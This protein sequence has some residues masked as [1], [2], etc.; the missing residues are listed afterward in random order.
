[1]TTKLSTSKKKQPSSSEGP[2]LK[3]LETENK[4][5]SIELKEKTEK[6]LR[7][8]A[9]LSNAQKRLEK[10]KQYHEELLRK[11]Y[12]EVLLDFYDVL[13][14]AYV[15]GDPKPGLKLLM[16]NLEKFFDSEHVKPIVCVGQCFDP[17]YHH[18]ITT[19]ENENSQDNCIIEEVK[20]GYLCDEKVLRPSQVIV[21]KKKTREDQR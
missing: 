16:A 7:A 19:V 2:L 6:Y 12:L 4:R 11:K 9:E 10:E 5:L 3:T 14:K 15:D 17:Q 20:K 18:A 1:M 21:N 8:V 13:C